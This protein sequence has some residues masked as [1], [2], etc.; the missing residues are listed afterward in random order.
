MFNISK[1][2]KDGVL[3]EFSQRTTDILIDA[4][5][6]K[7]ENVDLKEIKQII[8]N[9]SSIEEEQE[10]FSKLRQEQEQDYAEILSF[11]ADNINFIQN[12]AS[13]D[14]PDEMRLYMENKLR[15]KQEVE[16]EE[17]LSYS[18]DEDYDVDPD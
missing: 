15:Q 9:C 17:Y 13:L 5:H 12:I 11:I 7:L 14:I 8:S 16:A 6:R 18:D 10:I 3:S 1:N 4:K 2:K